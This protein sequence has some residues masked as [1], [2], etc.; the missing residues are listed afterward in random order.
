MAKEIKDEDNDVSRKEGSRKDY[1]QGIRLAGSGS[2][3]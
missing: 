2:K 3:W 1:A